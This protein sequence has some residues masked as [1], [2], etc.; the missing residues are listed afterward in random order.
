M[1]VATQSGVPSSFTAG[2]AVVFIVQDAQHPASLWT[3]D[4]VLTRDGKSLKTIRATASVDDFIVGLAGADSVIA[5]GRTQFVEIFTLIAEPTQRESGCSG[6]LTIL[7][8][9]TGNLDLSK[10]QLAL[11]ACNEAIL[12]LVARPNASV[13]FVGQS[14]TSQNIDSLLKARDRL[15]VL[16]DNELNAL[17][18][19]ENGGFRIIRNRF[20]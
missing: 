13:N 18:L 3:L 6:W 12:K 8:N 4:F 1:P 20:R 2:D 10:N 15:Q 19:S 17:G 16:V 5:P 14:Y 11:A 9:P 7:P